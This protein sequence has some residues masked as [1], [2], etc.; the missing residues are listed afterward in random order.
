MNDKPDNDNSTENGESGQQD[1]LTRS[2]RALPREIEPPRD[3]WKGVEARIDAKRQRS[4]VVRRSAQIGAGAAVLLAAA[5]VILSVRWTKEPQVDHRSPSPTASE[6]PRVSPAPT[7]SED[8]MTA[9]APEESTYRAALAALAPT[10]GDRRKT[11][12]EKD[13]ARVEASLQAIDTAIRV[14]RA[15]L[16]AHPD[17]ADLR[18]ELDAEYEQKIDTMN[19]VLDWTTRS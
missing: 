10:F 15:S 1:E 7:A 13:M 4:F 11:L 12:P 6:A 8:P 9:L 5:A 16:V 19:D 14:T 3:L 18:G 2:A 17:D